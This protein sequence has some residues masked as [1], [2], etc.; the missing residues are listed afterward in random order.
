M[1]SA[2]GHFVFQVIGTM[3]AIA[4]VWLALAGFLGVMGE[5]GSGWQGRAMGGVGLVAGVALFF[6]GKIMADENR[7]MKRR[8]S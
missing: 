5:I 6:L 4:A 1:I 2:S 3:L 7:I 8:R